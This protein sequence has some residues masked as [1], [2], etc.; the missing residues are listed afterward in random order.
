MMEFADLAAITIHDAKNRLGLVATR[1][2]ANGDAETLRGVLESA[3]S[4]TRLLAYYKAEKNSLATQIEARVPADLLN[5]LVNDLGK[6][7]SLILAADLSKAPTLWFYDESLIRM[8]LLDALYN[9]LRH[10]RTKVSLAASDHGDWLEWVVADDGDGYPSEML[11]EP[12]GMQSLSR[13]GTGIG[14]YLAQRVAALHK[15]SGHCG[16]I[17]LDNNRGAVF[18]LLLPK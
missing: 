15:N 9:A 17:E 16:R 10:A 3:A 1:A 8:V 11:G 5:E 12:Q 13:D 4:L 2:E 18:R 6:Q 7:T 14:L